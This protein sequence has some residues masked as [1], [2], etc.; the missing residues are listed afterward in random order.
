MAP[1]GIHVLLREV[2]AIQSDEE[3]GL[4]ASVREL[5]T[6][7][8]A[9][10]KK[11]HRQATEVE[12]QITHRHKREERSR[13]LEKAPGIGPITASALVATIGNA[14]GFHNGCQLA[15]W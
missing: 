10:V 12:Q 1:Q 2:P 8:L 9:H 11:L 3:N 6:R 5:F 14:Q 15:A 4:L 13:K 7:L